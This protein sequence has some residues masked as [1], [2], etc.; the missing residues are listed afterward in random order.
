MQLNRQ[1][2]LQKQ[3]EQNITYELTAKDKNEAYSVLLKHATNYENFPDD[4]GNT[5]EV[6]EFLNIPYNH[7]H[8]KLYSNGEVKKVLNQEAIAK[9]WEQVKKA[10]KFRQLLTYVDEFRFFKELNPAYEDSL[11]YILKTP[12]YIVF[13][14]PVYRTPNYHP[15]PFVRL[16]LNCNSIIFAGNSVSFRIQFELDRVE[17][18]FAYC[19]S[20]TL[21]F[22][23][24]G[25]KM[26]NLYKQ[27]YAP[28]IPSP[29]EYAFFYK[30]QYKYEVQTAKL[31][32]A[33]AIFR[34][35]ANEDL[36]YENKINI[37]LK[38]TES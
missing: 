6:S 5:L 18:G 15:D 4:L 9:K 33:K 31:I 37:Q 17:N 3:I 21:K 32:Q 34:E 30:A 19:K 36:I 23:T 27:G 25:R 11:E 2:I 10:D 28:V 1:T 29:L 14:P 12:H 7:L 35:Q 38:P 24:D 16:E 20:K 13:F 22:S 8:L 26:K